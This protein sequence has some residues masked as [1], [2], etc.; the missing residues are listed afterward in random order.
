[1][2]ESVEISA[3]SSGEGWGD[4]FWEMK[5]LLKSTALLR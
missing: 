1:M 2:V 4:I 3:V 5:G